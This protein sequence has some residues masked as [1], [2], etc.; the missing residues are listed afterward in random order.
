MRAPTGLRPGRARPFGVGVTFPGMEMIS[1]GPTIT[2]AHSPDER[3]EVAS[4][5]KV[6]DLLAATLGALQ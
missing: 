3:L 2:G 4:V 5:A 6:Y 1:V